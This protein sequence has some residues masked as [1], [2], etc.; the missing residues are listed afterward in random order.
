MV[1]FKPST[2][3]RMQCSSINLTFSIARWKLLHKHSL[4]IDARID[5]GSTHTATEYLFGRAEHSVLTSSRYDRKPDTE[6]DKNR[7]GSAI[8]PLHSRDVA[9]PLGERA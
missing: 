7:T 6:R 5:V 3:P 9:Q 4:S 1:S 2:M 8:K